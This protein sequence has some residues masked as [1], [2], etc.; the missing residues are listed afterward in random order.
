MDMK[1]TGMVRRI[2]ELG[3]IVIPKE[4]RRNLRMKEGEQLEIFTED[5]ETV[6]LKKYSQVERLSH[7]AEAYALAVGKATG[8][9]CL[10]TD[11]E[12]VVSVSTSAK[13]YLVGEKISDILLEIMARRQ[14]FISQQ[15]T[16]SVSVCPSLVCEDAS[17][18]IISPIVCDGIV[19]GSLILIGEAGEHCLKEYAV[20]GASFLG[21]ITQ[22]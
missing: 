13:K 6:V 9:L 17:V 11:N 8:S 3:R 16:K 14:V 22:V 2:D 19:C 18:Q 12:K 5:N 4:I 15:Y 7:Y 1:A 20:T 10:I 21:N